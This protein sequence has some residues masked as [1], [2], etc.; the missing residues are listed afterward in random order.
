MLSPHETFTK[1]THLILFL[2][3]EDWLSRFY[4]ARVRLGPSAM[5]DQCPVYPPKAVVWRTFRDVDSMSALPQTS[6]HRPAR[7][8]GPLSANRDLTRCSKGPVRLARRHWHG[9]VVG[10]IY[11]GAGRRVGMARVF[12]LALFAPA[13]GPRYLPTTRLTTMAAMPAST[14]LAI[15]DDRMSVIG[16]DPDAC[17]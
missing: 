1:A 8:E 10:R 16:L 14:A 6:R 4:A 17:C 3:A 15:G 9:K 12:F 13:L 2:R 5:L 7:Y 11:K